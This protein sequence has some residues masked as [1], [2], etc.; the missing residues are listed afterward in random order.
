MRPP[1]LN[2]F[3]MSTSELACV[4]AALIL[5]DD[6]LEITVRLG[7]CLGGAGGA[8]DAMHASMP[9]SAPAPQLNPACSP[10]CV[11]PEN[12]TTLT[13][14]AGIEVEPYWPGLFAK[15]V[16]KKSIDDFIVNVGA[17][18][19]RGG[20]RRVSGGRAVGALGGAMHVKPVPRCM[21]SSCN[22]RDAA[23]CTGGMWLYSRQPS[24]GV[25]AAGV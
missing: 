2:C 15:L 12:I 21:R 5:H 19:R 9:F 6:G 11:Q 17:G 20:G 8:G 23:A 1:G 25:A 7:R 4:Y 22:F 14:A 16:E 24:A 18:E 10:A 13:K 3:R